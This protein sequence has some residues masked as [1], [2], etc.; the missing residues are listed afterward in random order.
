MNYSCIEFGTSPFV[1]YRDP[2]D[3]GFEYEI[4]NPWFD[5]FPELATIDDY[6]D[7]VLPPSTL[8][9]VIRMEVQD[10]SLPVGK[11]TSLVPHPDTAFVQSAFIEKIFCTMKSDSEVYVD[12][13]I[14]AYIEIAKIEPYCGQKDA[15]EYAARTGTYRIDDQVEQ[16][17]R[18]NC[19]LTMDHNGFGFR[20]GKT[21]IYKGYGK[22]PGQPMSKYL[23]PMLSRDDVKRERQKI[24]GTV[25]REQ[26]KRQQCV[27]A[28]ELA[29]C[30]GYTVRYARLSK[31]GH[32]RGKCFPL[33]CSAEVFDDHGNRTLLPVD[34]NTILIDRAACHYNEGS[35]EEAVAHEIV[36]LREHR[37][38]FVLQKQYHNDLQSLEDMT[39]SAKTYQ[40]EDSTK[41]LRIIE[42]Q[43]NAIGREIMLPEEEVKAAAGQIRSEI[44]TRG[45]HRYGS[46]PEILVKE[47][48]ARFHTTQNSARNRLQAFGD[49]TVSGALRW[50][51]DHPVPYFH[52]SDYACDA[53]KTYLISAKDAVREFSRNQEFRKAVTEGGFIFVQNF[54]CRD[55]EKYVRKLKDRVELTAY[56]LNHIEECCLIFTVTFGEADAVYD[57][58]A[59]H[60]NAVT[61]KAVPS[62]SRMTKEELQQGRLQRKA[63]LKEVFPMQFY[64]A[65]NY[66]MTERGFTDESLSEEIGCSP[67]TISR[68]RSGTRRPDTEKMTLL[69]VALSLDSTLGHM[70]LQKSGAPM[71]TGEPFD[72]Y[73]F[74]ITCCGDHPVGDVIGMIEDAKRE[75]I[76]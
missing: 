36:H 40:D 60:L 11:S 39:G 69:C 43:A 47:V 32:I 19:M 63:L 13:I 7:K 51:D 27:R 14:R 50:I 26:S 9:N 65:L 42:W 3:P 57:P 29:G 22:K 52:R 46:E 16:Q 35:I 72:T 10:G 73:D 61:K 38:F 66:L 18:M 58:D 56:A 70:M 21:E 2:Y 17:Y 31:D 71:G 53:D 74:I 5:E 68:Y 20:T 4:A 41:E 33:A 59:L 62:Y 23:V 1:L 25:Y 28:T 15:D 64:E 54:F 49:R 6:V 8:E 37:F 12:L 34:A 48:A 45:L 55:D 76:A 75:A 30:M 44:R 67:K 24:I